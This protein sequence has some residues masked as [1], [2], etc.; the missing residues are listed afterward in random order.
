VLEVMESGQFKEMVGLFGCLCN[1]MRPPTIRP[2]NPALLLPARS[3]CLIAWCRSCL[4]GM[5][6]CDDSHNWPRDDPLRTRSRDLKLHFRHICN[7]KTDLLLH[8]LPLDTPL[9]N[10]AQ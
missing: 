6:E 5:L 4:D 10:N 7:P 1:R 8:G 2:R 3:L 9:V